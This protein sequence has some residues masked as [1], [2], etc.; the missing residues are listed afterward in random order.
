MPKKFAKQ[1]GLEESLS[2]D[3]N[4]ALGK[5]GSEQYLFIVVFLFFPSFVFLLHPVT[6][7]QL[8]YINDVSIILCN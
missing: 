3:E 5:T 7:N 6:A 4:T 8:L 1:K 2:R